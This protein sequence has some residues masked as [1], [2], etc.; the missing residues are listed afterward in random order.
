MGGSC[1]GFVPSVEGEG[2]EKLEVR[3]EKLERLSRRGLVGRGLVGA[4]RARGEL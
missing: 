4:L 2:S 1:G 3:S